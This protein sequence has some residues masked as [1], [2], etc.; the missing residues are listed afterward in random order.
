MPMRRSSNGSRVWRREIHEAGSSTAKN[1]TNADDTAGVLRH[2]RAGLGGRCGE[3]SE[4][5][6]GDCADHGAPADKYAGGFAAGIFR[7]SHAETGRGGGDGAAEGR[8]S[9]ARPSGAVYRSRRDRGNR[10]HRLTQISRWDAMTVHA[11]GAVNATV[12]Y[13]EDPAYA[14]GGGGVWGRKPFAGGCGAS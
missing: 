11:A 14:Q 5:E 9:G 13:S 6:G 8:D 4:A 3:S 2:Q 12:I 10:L 7:D 1:C